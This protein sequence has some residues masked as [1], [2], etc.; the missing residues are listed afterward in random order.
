M[1]FLTIPEIIAH[2][3]LRIVIV[4]DFPSPWSQAARTVFEQKGLDYVVG[5]QIAGGENA[6]LVAWSGQN[7]GPVVAYGEEP[8]VHRW[9]D[10]L[11]LA[12]RLAPKPSLLPEDPEERVRVIGL[13]HEIAGDG[14]IG[15][16]GRVAGFH[17]AM[18]ADAAPDFAVAIANKWGYTEERGARAIAELV[19]RL[20]YLG[21]QAKANRAGGSQYLV[22]NALS[23]VDLYWAAMSILVDPLPEETM[24][25]LEGMRPMFEY[26]GQVPEVATAIEPALIEHRDFIVDRYFRTPFDYMG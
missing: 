18:S 17:P 6:E 25:T 14:G 1:K 21:E 7:S 4:K 5:G 16:W 15:W 19:T 13:L 12:E 23:A 11:M 22:G 24:P 9:M 26:L 10:I 8:P 3:G 2:P 20:R